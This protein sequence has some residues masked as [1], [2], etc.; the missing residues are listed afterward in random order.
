MILLFSW[1]CRQI[2][3]TLIV[4]DHQSTNLTKLGEKKNLC[5][6]HGNPAIIAKEVISTHGFK[7]L[8]FFQIFDLWIG[9][10][11]QTNLVLGFRYWSSCSIILDQNSYLMDMKTSI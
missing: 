5:G 6:D 9:R 1:I 8:F 2:W 10:D 3:L 11:H 4:D 7:F